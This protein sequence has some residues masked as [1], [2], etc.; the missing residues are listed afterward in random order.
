MLIRHIGA[1]TSVLVGRYLS[2]KI[3]IRSSRAR[4]TGDQLADQISAAK[5]FDLASVLELDRQS[6]TKFADRVD[7][8][9]RPEHMHFRVEPG[10][11]QTRKIF[12][13]QFRSWLKYVGMDMFTKVVEQA[14][15][16]A[17]NSEFHTC[18]PRQGH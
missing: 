4:N 7:V 11:E 3:R 6:E 10:P 18:T 13:Q 5:E 8:R 9:R 2:S 1:Y 16:S 14:V 12:L 17:R 15:H